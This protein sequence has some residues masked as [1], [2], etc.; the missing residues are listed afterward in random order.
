MISVPSYLTKNSGVNFSNMRSF[1]ISVV[2]LYRM[3]FFHIQCLNEVL[4]E[5]LNTYCHI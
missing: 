1:I 5:S 2:G 3:S 4:K